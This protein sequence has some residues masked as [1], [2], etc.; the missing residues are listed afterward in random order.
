MKDLKIIYLDIDKVLNSRSSIE[1]FGTDDEF[2][3]V[4]CGLLRKLVKNTCSHIVIISQRRIGNSIE[5]LR[6]MLKDHAGKRISSSIIDKVSDANIPR[7]GLIRDWEEANGFNGVYCII[8]D[9]NEG[10]SASQ[11]E[12][13]VQPDPDHGFHILDYGLAYLLLS[14]ETR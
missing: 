9:K 7:G 11:Q 8:D 5:D 4:S 6:S 14:K 12:C 2:D 1:A 10:Y 3:P 13:L